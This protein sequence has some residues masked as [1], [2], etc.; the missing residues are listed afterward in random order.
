MGAS[1]SSSTALPLPS[2]DEPSVDPPLDPEP[3]PPGFVPESEG[4]LGAGV[5]VGAGVEPDTVLRHPGSKRS[6]LPSRSLSLPSV[7][8]Q[9]IAKVSGVLSG[10]LGS[11]P[12]CLS[13]SSG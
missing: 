1:P 12:S 13:T 6:R 9:T 2:P 7:Q 10:L 4:P 3:L 8:V 11:E 5:A